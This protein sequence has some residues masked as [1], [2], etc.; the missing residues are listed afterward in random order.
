MITSPRALMLH[1][2][3]VTLFICSPAVVSSQPCCVT[4]DLF[5]LKVPIVDAPQFGDSCCRGIGDDDLHLTDTCQTHNQD[6]R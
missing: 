5:T 1:T 4:I 2:C 3:A 6:Q